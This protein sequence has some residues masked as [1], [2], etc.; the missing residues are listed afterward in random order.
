MKAN[1]HFYLSLFS[2]FSIL[3]FNFG[4]LVWEGGEGL[5]G[6]RGFGRGKKARQKLELLDVEEGVLSD[7]FYRTIS[8][9]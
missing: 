2:A 5:E 9:L 3:L 7:K 8:P 4:V 1:S 6:G